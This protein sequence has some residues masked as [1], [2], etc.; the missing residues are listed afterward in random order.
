[1][2]RYD[3]FEGRHEYG[4]LQLELPKSELTTCKAVLQWVPRERQTVMCGAKYE[5]TMKRTIGVTRTEQQEVEALLSGSIGGE[6][7]GKLESSVKS[8][9][10]TEI[11]LSTAIEEEKK[12]TVE[13]KPCYELQVDFFQLVCI[14]DIACEWKP[15]LGKRKYLERRIDVHLNQF[16]Q[17]SQATPKHR[18][19]GC[20]DKGEAT[21]SLELVGPNFGMSEPYVVLNNRLVGFTTGIVVLRGDVQTL[22][23]PT[24][25]YEW[26]PSDDE[27]RDYTI[28]LRSAEERQLE[29]FLEEEGLDLPA[30]TLPDYLRFLAGIGDAS[31]VRVKV[32]ILATA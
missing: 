23:A 13:A 2:Q 3:Y 20:E 19:C 6:Y 32:R 26:P 8:R 22:R 16:V 5:W 31:R 18:E 25:S 11:T 1:V 27:P 17:R 28:D 15:L 14:L 29:P 24:S 4:E 7:L 30:E 10:S 21:G 12:F 9:I